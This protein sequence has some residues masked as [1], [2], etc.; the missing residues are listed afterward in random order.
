MNSIATQRDLTKG[1]QQLERQPQSPE[2]AQKAETKG[3]VDLLV[4]AIPT[5]PLALYTFLIAGITMTIDPGSDERLTMRWIILAA[6]AAFIALWMI[7]SYRRQPGSKKRKLPWPEV[8]SAI[9][10]FAAWGLVM[11]ESPLAAELSSS[12]QMVWTY[13]IVAAAVAVLGLLTGSMKKPVKK[14]G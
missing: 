7:S 14:E 4:A 8:T 11:P 5:E 12:N 3:Y 2:D 13:I 10:A 6:S 1:A 9:V